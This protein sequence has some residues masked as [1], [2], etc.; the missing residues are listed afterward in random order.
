[1][2]EVCYSNSEH[3]SAIGRHMS[4]TSKYTPDLLGNAVA[5]V[6][7]MADLL[8]Y[9]DLKQSGGNHRSLWILIRQYG[10]ST[11][12]FTG[13]GWS[14]GKGSSGDNRVARGASSRSR[15]HDEVFCQNSPVLSNHT[16]VKR[17]RRQG[18]L[19]YVCAVCGLSEWLDRPIALH[20]DHINGVP[21]D[22][23]LPENLRF[24]CPNCHQQTE[25]WGARK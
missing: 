13:Q 5:Q 6:T 23:R 3:A 22:N 16:L 17:I 8:R 2:A 12:H 1:M 15:P 11:S 9:F 10:I 18:L 4:R 25:T 20:L 14:R 21:N 19:P 7:T 24:L